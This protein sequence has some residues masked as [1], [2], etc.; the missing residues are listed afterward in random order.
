MA[1]LH[2][3]I[4]YLACAFG[5]KS[6]HEAGLPHAFVLKVG[7]QGRDIYLNPI[8]R[9]GLGHF[10]VL[11]HSIHISLLASISAQPTAV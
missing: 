11:F 5:H 2:S 9:K 10:E 3:R 6:N 1:Y 4:P 7:L 8:E